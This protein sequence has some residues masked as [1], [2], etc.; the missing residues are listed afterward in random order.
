M[1][2]I[3]LTALFSLI[4]FSAF[5][6][7]RVLEK[8]YK[9]LF[10]CEEDDGDTWTEVGLVK[11]AGTPS[12][13]NLL[14]VK[15]IENSRKLVFNKPAILIKQSPLVQEYQDSGSI[16]KLSIARATSQYVGRFSMLAD[17]PNSV[18]NLRVNCFYSSEISY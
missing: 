18:S 14:V 3:L 7:H 6:Q 8:T 16:V 15:H 1:K 4:S 13:Y 17:G 10:T 9:T 5:A 2:S 12:G 11:T